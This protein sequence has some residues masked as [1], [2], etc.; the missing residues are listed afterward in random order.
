MGL[1]SSWYVNFESVTDYERSP[2]YAWPMAAII[3]IFTS[4]DE[5]EIT[6]QLQELVSST[7]GL[8]LIHESINTF[9]VSDWTRQWCK[10][11][12]TR[13]LLHTRPLLTSRSVSWVRLT[14]LYFP[15]MLLT[16]RK[17]G[18]WTLRADDFGS[19][20]QE[21]GD[22]ETE[23]SGQRYYRP[24]W[25]AWRSWRPWRPWRSWKPWMV[26]CCK[27]R[28]LSIS[29]TSCRRAT[30]RGRSQI[31]VTDR[32]GKA[33]YGSC[34]RGKQASLH[35]RKY[36][37]VSKKRCDVVHASCESFAIR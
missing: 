16:G 5:A 25:M 8:G 28:S 36:M 12:E 7:D 23:L 17:L 9:N 3:R 2:G 32:S 15:G 13:F 26:R 27:R 10:S 30:G 31:A 18:K 24:A 35:S 37:H 21:A 11:P 19:G 6:Q 4:D 22:S 14:S 29:V 20:G 33:P 1:Y 34:N